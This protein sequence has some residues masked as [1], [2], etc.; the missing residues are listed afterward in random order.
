VLPKA[1]VRFQVILLLNV[2]RDEHE[3]KDHQSDDEAVFAKQ[4]QV[5]PIYLCNAKEL[6]HFEL[7]F[8]RQ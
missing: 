2:V 5:L 1:K 4:V 8:K 3:T 6:N 7:K